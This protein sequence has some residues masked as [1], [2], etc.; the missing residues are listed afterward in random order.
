MS[1][2]TKSN[3]EKNLTRIMFE[4]YQ[5]DHQAA[6][7]GSFVVWVA[8][9]VPI[10]LLKGFDL[11]VA[12]PE[13]HAAMCAAK[14]IGADESRK[15]ERL[16]YSMDLCSYARIDL[17]TVYDQ[18]RGSP[19]K[20][21]PKPDLLISDNNNCSHLVKW[22][23]VHHRQMGVPHFVL[24]V[25]FCYGPQQEKDRRYIAGQ[26]RDL[27]H[28]IEQLTGQRFDLRKAR[29]ALRHTSEAVGHWKR[30]LGLAA[31][32]PSGITA[33]ETFIHMAPYITSLRGTPEL[34]EH[35][36]ILADEGRER[37]ARAAFPVPH[38]RHRLLWDGIAPWHQLRSMSSRL[39]GLGANVIYAPY[40]SCLGAVEGGVDQVPYDGSDPVEFLAR[41]QNFSIC[42]YGLD[43]R[44]RAMSEMIERF[45]VDAVIF[46]SNRSCKVYSIMQM[47]LKRMISE[48]FG[49]PTVM[50]EIDH[51]DV[52][53]YDESQAFRQIET[54]LEMG[55]ASRDRTASQA[56][57]P[58]VNPA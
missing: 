13:N 25:P 40:T 49:I 39:A 8:I 55:S 43:L 18:G 21:L 35:Y 51:A 48:R 26:Y 14:G 53:M 32:R 5:A 7:K 54:M 2:R 50:I 44:F 38:E 47:D 19:I 30:F 6:S 42:P 33:F 28:T 41:T 58:R 31:H 9:I 36:R 23:D 22:F 52:R 20:G 16:G 15:A 10:E 27:I 46:A 24:D 4:Q 29:E 11:V 45:G 3:A 17:G 37:L 34:V 56:G 12:V 57:S 1:T